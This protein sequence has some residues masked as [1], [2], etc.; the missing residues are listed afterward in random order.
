M[1]LPALLTITGSLRPGSV[2]VELLDQAEKLALELGLF[3]QVSRLDFAALPFYDAGLDGPLTPAEILF[4]RER[5]AEADGLL[6]SSPEYN[7]SIPGMLKNGI[8]W[9]SRPRGAAVLAGKAT[10][11]M[12]AS[13]GAGGGRRGQEHLRQILRVAGADVVDHEVVAW[14]GAR[15]G[16]PVDEATRGVLPDLLGALAQRA[17]PRAPGT[18]DRSAAERTA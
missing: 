12:S 9:L 17:D 7:G 10:A 8:D 14:G 5:V 13:P 16:G 3:G 11:V 15:D 4:A 2:N 18:A 1:S 6:I